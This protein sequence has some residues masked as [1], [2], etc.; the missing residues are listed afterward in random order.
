MDFKLRV[1]AQRGCEDQKLVF[2]TLSHDDRERVTIMLDEP[3]N[4]ATILAA[5]DTAWL[6]LRDLAL[7]AASPK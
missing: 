1:V 4:D 2:I 5:L 3:A 6:K 7:M